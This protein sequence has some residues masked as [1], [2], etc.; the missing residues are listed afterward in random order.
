METKI[1]ELKNYLPEWTSAK[2]QG[3]VQG[4]ARRSWYNDNEALGDGDS[5]I[6]TKNW[7][8]IEPVWQEYVQEQFGECLNYRYPENVLMVLMIGAGAWVGGQQVKGGRKGIRKLVFELKTDENGMLLLPDIVQIKL[9][10]KKKA[11]VRAFLISH[12]HES[13]LATSE[14]LLR[15]I[16]A[17]TKL[18]AL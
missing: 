9:E 5:F 6:K 1:S 10:E 2:D 3:Q 7:E 11:I 18:F 8:D 12:Y 4:K 13:I 16:L 15:L 14:M 17:L